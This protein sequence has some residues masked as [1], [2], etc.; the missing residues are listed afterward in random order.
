MW[1]R[2]QKNDISAWRFE[3]NVT[4]LGE[5]LIYLIY[6]ISFP[7]PEH[8]LCMKK[9]ELHEDDFKHMKLPLLPFSFQADT[10]TVGMS[11]SC[12]IA[13]TRFSEKVSNRTIALR[14]K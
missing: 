8:W 7:T 13:F 11:K 14:R 9:G 5:L 3:V 1:T 12:V 10:P 2:K 4:A 6:I